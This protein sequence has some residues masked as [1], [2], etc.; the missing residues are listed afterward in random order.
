MAGFF[1]IGIYYSKSKRNIGT[2]WSS[3]QLFEASFIYTILKRYNWQ[4][5]DTL[6]SYR[7]VPLFHHED[8]THFVESL[9]KACEL[10]GV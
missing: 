1:G 5:T 2:L 7:H 10:I 9:P 4:P 6:K 8:L 3:A